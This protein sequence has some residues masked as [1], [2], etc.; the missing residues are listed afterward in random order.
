MKRTFI[1]GIWGDITKNGIRDGKMRKD[2]DAI[3]QNSYNENF[4]VYVFGRENWTMLSNEG[5]RV[6]LIDEAPVKYDM[7]KQLYRHKLDILEHATR[8]Y[9]E[10]VFLDW[11]CVPTAPLPDDF[12]DKMHKKAPFQ[13]NLFQYRTKKCL[14]RDRDWRKVC[15]GGFLYLRDHRIALVFQNNY[16]ELESWVRKQKESR[17][18]QGKKLR[19]REEALIFDDEPSISKWVDDS[20]GGWQG[21]EKYWEL[22][23]P[24]F[25]NLKKK[26][27]YPKDM[28]NTKRECFLHW[29]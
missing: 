27:V 10:I 15:N 18:A 17:E 3:K 26:S 7:K 1:R 16:R 13:A 4:V 20:M 12:W 8:D 28:L 24:D 25:C 6:K 23:E 5:F 14:W 19:F 29:G 2:I 21:I 22:F 11:D 9:D